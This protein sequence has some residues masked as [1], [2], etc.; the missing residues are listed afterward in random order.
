MA[1]TFGLS[2]GHGMKKVDNGFC[3]HHVHKNV[4]KMSSI[5]MVVRLHKDNISNHSQVVDV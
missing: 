4:H 1:F 5:H 2:R 3:A